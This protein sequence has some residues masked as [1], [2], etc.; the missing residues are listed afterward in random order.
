MQEKKS[1]GK[2][3]AKSEYG[4]CTPLSLVFV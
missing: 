4:G 2:T 3:L 1:Y